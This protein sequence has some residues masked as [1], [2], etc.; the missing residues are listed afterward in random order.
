MRPS[1]LTPL[2]SPSPAHTHTMTPIGRWM[3]VTSLIG[4]PIPF[5]FPLSPVPLYHR[6]GHALIAW[7]YIPIA[8]PQI[9][10]W[11][12]HIC[13]RYAAP[14]PV[15][16]ER[17]IPSS[18]M[19]PV[20]V[21]VIEKKLSFN[22]RGKVHIGAGDNHHGWRSGYDYAGQGNIN[23]YI[24]PRIASNRK[25]QSKNSKHSAQKICNQ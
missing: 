7:R 9:D 23:V 1:V 3:L 4:I 11:R 20:P 5:L 12:R 13:D 24:Y 2:H 8:G 6:V 14:G 25:E 16:S 22:I 15:V 17:I 19:G 21:P 18:P 10:Q